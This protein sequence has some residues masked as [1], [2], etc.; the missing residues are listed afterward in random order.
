M[1]TP[2][3]EE[4]TGFIHG[5]E[6]AIKIVQNNPRDHEKR[7]L[8]EWRHT[9]MLADRHGYCVETKPQPITPCPPPPMSHVVPAALFGLCVFGALCATLIS[10]SN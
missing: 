4:M 10:H 7:L 1:H 5:L 3:Q 6:V 8:N 9:L 2:T